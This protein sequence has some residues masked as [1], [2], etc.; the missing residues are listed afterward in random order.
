MSKRG[1]DGFRDTSQFSGAP[2]TVEVKGKSYTISPL[3]V[4]D[5]FAFD[6]YVRSRGVNA[7]LASEQAKLLPD[8]ERARMVQQLCTADV[9]A[10]ALTETLEG[11]AWLCWRSLV[12]NHP[13]I[14]LDEVAQ[15]IVNEP[16]FLSVLK[17]LGDE[18]GD[19]KRPPAKGPR[20]GA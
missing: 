9:D 5:L 8:D 16:D 15:L 19:K 2:M 18:G 3:S 4:G 6:N 17:S 11:A 20:G 13:E 10:D 1:S 14:T 7:F 12:K